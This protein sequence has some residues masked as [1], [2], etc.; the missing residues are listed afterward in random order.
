MYCVTCRILQDLIGISKFF[1]EQPDHRQKGMRDYY[2]VISKP[3]WFR[4]S[5]YYHCG[6]KVFIRMHFVLI[7]LFKNFSGSRGLPT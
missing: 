1:L 7:C 2:D 5:K 3:M 6:T 4:A